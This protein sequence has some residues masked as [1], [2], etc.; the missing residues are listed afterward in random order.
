MRPLFRATLGGL[1]AAVSVSLVGL[2]PSAQAATYDVTYHLGCAL[3]STRRAGLDLYVHVTPAGAGAYYQV[4]RWKYNTD[5]HFLAD[6]MDVQF[7]TTNGEPDY[8]WLAKGGTIASLND[9]PNAFD[10]N[11]TSSTLYSNPGTFN[12]QIRVWDASSN[13]KCTS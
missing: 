4:Y 10:E 13:S 9:V 7:G 3:N 6:R 5:A 8:T 2:A 12:A 1:M 11:I